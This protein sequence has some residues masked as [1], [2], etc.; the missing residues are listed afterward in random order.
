MPL[1]VKPA[2][3]K[4][5]PQDRPWEIDD[6]RDPL[7]GSRAIRRLLG[8]RAPRITPVKRYDS[9]ESAGP[10]I[11]IRLGSFP[12]GHFRLSHSVRADLSQCVR[13]QMSAT[14]SATVRCCNRL[15]LSRPAESHTGCPTKKIDSRWVYTFKH[16]KAKRLIPR[17]LHLKEN[18]WIR[19]NLI[20]GDS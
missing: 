16:R 10:R 12:A 19:K 3:R 14:D 8:P 17:N 13:P 7:A 4:V 6:A 15:R 20:E 2:F 11:R 5:D 18:P 1:A 9:I